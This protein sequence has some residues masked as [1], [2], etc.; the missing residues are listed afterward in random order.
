VLKKNKRLARRAM[1]CSK[2]RWLPVRGT[3]HWSF[4]LPKRLPK[5]RYVIRT[6]AI[7]FA[8]NVQHS[9]T[10]RLRLR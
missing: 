7:D 2:H 8:G 1:R 10:R 6:R 9:R 4:R 5:G 3:T